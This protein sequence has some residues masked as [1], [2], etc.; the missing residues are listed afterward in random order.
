MSQYFQNMNETYIKKH[1]PNHSVFEAFAKT[2]KKVGIGVYIFF[3]IIL[4]GSLAGLVWSVNTM[5]TYRQSGDTDMADAGMMICAFFAVF[6]L[7]SVFVIA[8]TIWRGKRDSKDWIKKSMKKSKLS[9]SE[10]REFERQA[11]ASDSYILKFLDGVTAAISGGKDGILTRD[12]IYLADI[13]L[14]VM[15]CKDLI[16]ACLIDSVIFVRNRPVH[17]LG[18]KLLSKN[19][20]ESFAEVSPEA[21]KALIEVLLQ[22][23]STIET[24]GGRVMTEKEYDKYKK[25]ELLKN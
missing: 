15:R 17:Y 16:S 18:I 13:N 11:M 8:L 3:G 6:A 4:A 25:T 24:C 10:I 22:E 9:E 7:I 12:F 5:N 21:G 23:Y 20:A 2:T 1:Y 19:G 14:T